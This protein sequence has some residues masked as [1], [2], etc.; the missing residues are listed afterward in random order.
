MEGFTAEYFCR[1]CC[2]TK[3]QYH[4]DRALDEPIFRQAK[5][6]KPKHFERALLKKGNAYSYKGIK[7]QTV[8]DK[9][10]LNICDPSLPNCLG[11]D[12][13]IDGVVDCDLASMI[14][15]FV[16]TKNWFSYKLLNQRIK[17][18]KCKLN[19]SGNK[20]AACLRNKKKK[21]GGHA[22]QNW[23]LLRLLPL[24]IGDK[25]DD[26][27]DSIWQLYLLLKRICELAC[28]PALTKDQ[29][30]ILRGML[31]DYMKLRKPLK[32]KYKPKHHYFHH[33]ADLWEYLGPLIHLWSMGFEQYHQFFKRVGRNCNNFINL[34]FSFAQK[35]QLMQ[36]YQSTGV[37]FPSDAVYDY[38]FPLVPESYSP[39]LQETLKN[40]N[41][42]SNALVVKKLTFN[43]V[44][45]KKG[46]H[47]LLRT[48]DSDI[49]VGLIDLIVF[50]AHNYF[51]LVT[52]YKAVLL[53]DYGLYKILSNGNTLSYMLPLVDL[54]NPCPHPVYD[55]K[56]RTCFSLKH[57]LLP[58]KL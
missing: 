6:R 28:A 22:V 5:W 8:F 45:Y 12:L 13:F 56:G 33:M 26:P 52:E 20:P 11:H 29:I 24:L 2:I 51:F 17:A 31:D 43:G 16:K 34:I 42:T 25:I 40:S 4:E 27:S 39:P 30:S 23:T 47:L 55:F 19:D 48:N 54:E 7:R 15:Y 57:A 3:T 46:Q 18:F 41:L 9:L 44:C 49:Y 38:A 58:P 37:L 14:K 21:L 36:A 50:D 32:N 1:F 53:E 35:H 10:K